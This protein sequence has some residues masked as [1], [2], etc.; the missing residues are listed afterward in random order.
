MR[1]GAFARSGPT[2]SVLGVIG[3]DSVP[4][5]CPAPRPTF[6][7]AWPILPPIPLFQ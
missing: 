2:F 3:P 5:L 1:L 4:I 7:A 6:G